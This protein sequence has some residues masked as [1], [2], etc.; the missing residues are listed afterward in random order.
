MTPHAAAARTLL[1]N[2]SRTFNDSLSET[3]K[4]HYTVGVWPFRNPHTASLADIKSEHTHIV[5]VTQ[6]VCTVVAGI[7][8][9]RLSDD[10][11]RFEIVPADPTDL[12]PEIAA[13]VG[14]RLAPEFAWKRGQAWPVKSVPTA[15]LLSAHRAGPPEVSLGGFRLLVDVD[16]VAHVYTPRGGEVHIHAGN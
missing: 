16:G 7:A 2:T 4:L 12:D 5:G 1:V 15:D 9:V 11:D 14:Q 13:L 8:D 10:G 6:G 3:E